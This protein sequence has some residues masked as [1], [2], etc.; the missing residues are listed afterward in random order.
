MTLSK[1]SAASGLAARI[2][3]GLRKLAGKEGIRLTEQSCGEMLGELLERVCNN[4]GAKA[5]VLVDE[6]D[7][8]VTS[9]MQDRGLALANRQVLND[10][11]ESLKT[12]VGYFHFAL[13]TGITGFSMTFPGSLANNFKVI[14]LRPGFAGICGF[15]AGDLDE[16]FGERFPGTLAGLEKAG[17]IARNAG[18]KEL[19]AKSL[20]ITPEIKSGPQVSF[21]RRDCER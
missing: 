8:P 18:T 20:D 19:K 21:S 11:I 16:Y 14:S 1:I 12:N 6:C 5:V 13:V 2:E 17:E 3:S 15:T 7:F 9:H 10:F 4:H